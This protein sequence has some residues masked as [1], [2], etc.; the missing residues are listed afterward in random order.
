MNNLVISQ[1][2]ASATVQFQ[3][4]TGSV[5][6]YGEAGKTGGTDGG[7][8]PVTLITVGNINNGATATGTGQ[9]LFVGH[10][11]TV[12]ASTVQIGIMTNNLGGGGGAVPQRV[13]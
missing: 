2:K 13:M 6:I 11:A 5:E 1:D 4:T 10:T 3:G 12:V 8:A 9:L 7:P